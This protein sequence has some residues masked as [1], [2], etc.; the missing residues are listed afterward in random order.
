M[1][2]QKY[3]VSVDAVVNDR[4]LDH[5]RFLAQVNIP[6]AERLYDEM[7]K[8][9]TEL[10]ENPKSCP[11]YFSAGQYALTS[12]TEAE[13]R[14]KLCGKRYRI[15]FEVDNNNVYVYDIQ[16]CRQDSDKNLL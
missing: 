9:I 14:Y 1:I 4:M 8:A 5:V 15:V 13:L 2:E 11:K 10:E 6:A 16:D 12:P 7:A 3:N